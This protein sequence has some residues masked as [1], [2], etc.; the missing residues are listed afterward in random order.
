M[1]PGLD[2]RVAPA[3]ARARRGQATCAAHARAGRTERG[4]RR[5]TGGPVQCRATVPL[6]GGFGLSVAQESAGCGTRSRGCAWAGPRRKGD[7]P[8]GCTVLFWICLN[9]IEIV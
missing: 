1:G 2:R 9:Q 7:G 8:P 4:E 6:T 5:L 3:S